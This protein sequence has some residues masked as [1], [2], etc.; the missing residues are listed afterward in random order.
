MHLGT[1]PNARSWAARHGDRPES[2][3][4]Y[5][6]LTNGESL[7]FAKGSSIPAIRFPENTPKIPDNF[8]TP[9]KSRPD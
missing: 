4:Q 6:S 9:P 5:A 3:S 8:F 1:E 2:E 7:M